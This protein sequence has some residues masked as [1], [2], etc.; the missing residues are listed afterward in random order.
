M[1]YHTWGGGTVIS[2]WYMVVL[3]ALGMVMQT[4]GV[5]GVLSAWLGLQLQGMLGLSMLYP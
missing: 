1:Q 5:Y 4:M 2:H 3:E